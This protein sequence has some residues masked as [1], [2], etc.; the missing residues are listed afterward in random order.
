ML[1]FKTK[2]F[3]KET[4]PMSS[5]PRVTEWTREFV[6]RQFDDL[7]PEACL[8]EITECLT[9]ENPELLDMARNCAADVDNGPK[10][11]V[12][13]GM[14]YQL[15]VSASSDTIEKQIMHPLPCVTAK[16]RDSLVREIDEERSESFTLRTIED[17]ERTNPELMQM[18]HGFASRHQDYLR[19]MQGFALLYRSLV[20]QSGADRK[21]LH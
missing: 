9:R 6:S 14:F 5:L 19:V 7:G 2:S 4:L 10:V 8:A 16:T 11:M 18:A 12:G 1:S 17:L 3:Q 21:Y 15:L 20:V 13:F